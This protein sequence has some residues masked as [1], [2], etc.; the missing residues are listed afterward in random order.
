MTWIGILAIVIAGL[1]L[2]P[3]VLMARVVDLRSYQH[4]YQG[5]GLINSDYSMCERE[6]GEEF[7]FSNERYGLEYGVREE[8]ART[9]KMDEPLRSTGETFSARSPSPFE[10]TIKRQAG[11]VWQVVA[12]MGGFSEVSLLLYDRL[13]NSFTVY[14]R[15]SLN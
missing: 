8:S 15:V 1:A 12:D 9:K 7:G 4:R 6:G 3:V 14:R 5:R 10:Y 13:G 2:I 11:D